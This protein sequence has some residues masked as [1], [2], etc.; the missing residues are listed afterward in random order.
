MIEKNIKREGENKQHTAKDYL[1]L[2]IYIVVVVGLG[3][4]CLNQFLEYR[5]KTVWLGDP[6]GLCSDLNPHLEK[7]IKDASVTTTYTGVK[8]EEIN[9]TKL[10]EESNLK[11]NNPN[12]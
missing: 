11:I 10:L 1:V 4:F 9:I 6:C 2:A 5:Y 3:L 8:T 12:S 7:C